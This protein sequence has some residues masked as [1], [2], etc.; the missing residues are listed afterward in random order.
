MKVR[1]HF[2]KTHGLTVFM[3]GLAVFNWE[4]KAAVKLSQLGLSPFSWRFCKSREVMST[5]VYA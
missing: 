3:N 2:R 4:Q 5:P 1:V